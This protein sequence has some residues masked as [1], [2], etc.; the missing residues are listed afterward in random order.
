MSG[1]DVSSSGGSGTGG[2]ALSGR[3]ILI[4]EDNPQNLRLLRAVLEL[5]NAK[6]LEAN[7]A[8]DGIEMARRERPDL[9]LM[10][11][12]MPEMDGMTATRLLKT[13][14]ETQDI[15]VVAVTASVLDMNKDQT[16]DAGCC[17][18]ITKP[19]DP[20]T[21]VETIIAFLT[22]KEEDAAP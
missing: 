19:I 20:A 22:P 4:I 11:I 17:G 2:G 8:R 7:H 16:R 5:E 14:P 15:P 3:C 6:V 10:D 12:Q 1:S 18:H 9:I 21:F 13:Y